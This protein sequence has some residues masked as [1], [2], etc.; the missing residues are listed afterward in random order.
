MALRGYVGHGSLDGRSIQD[1]LGWTV[2]PGVRMGENVAAVQTV[3]QGHSAFVAS[4]GH[5]RNI[6]NPAFRRVGIGVATAGDA[7]IRITEDFAE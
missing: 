6:L 7:G 4:A 5:L 3:E 2:R 1:R